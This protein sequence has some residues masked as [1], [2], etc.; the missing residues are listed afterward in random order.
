MVKVSKSHKVC[1]FNIVRE[2]IAHT[3]I[4]DTLNESPNTRVSDVL[5]LIL[6][7][8]D[9]VFYYHGSDAFTC[10]KN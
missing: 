5:Y 10:R 3:E 6:S 8:F 2:T 7:T 9:R 1:I 4:E